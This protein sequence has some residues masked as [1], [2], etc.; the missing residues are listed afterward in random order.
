MSNQGENE[1]ASDHED[2]D[3]TQSD[4]EE[5]NDV[6]WSEYQEIKVELDDYK[7]QWEFV[8]KKIN[9]SNL[10]RYTVFPPDLLEEFWDHLDLKLTSSFQP[11]TPE[12]MENHRDELYWYW[13]S[14]NIKI[15]FGDLANFVDLLDWTCV[16]QYHKLSEDQIRT[17]KDKLDWDLASQYQK[18]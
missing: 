16:S 15:P 11:L 17:Y 14:R 18:L 12:C 8:S 10:A 5:H 7:R 3:E 1:D 9:W 4:S 13:I 2:Q 6:A